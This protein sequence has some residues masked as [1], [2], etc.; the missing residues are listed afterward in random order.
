MYLLLLTAFLPPEKSSPAPQEEAPEI[1]TPRPH[2]ELRGK[3]FRERWGQWSLR[4]EEDGQVR[5]G[6]G[7]PVAEEDLEEAVV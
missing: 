6:L 7:R 1:W 2:R 4:W 3:R 5:S